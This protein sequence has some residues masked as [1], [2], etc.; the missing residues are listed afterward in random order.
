MIMLRSRRHSLLSTAHNKHHGVLRTQS[1]SS[2]DQQV[3]V[4]FWIQS[5][6]TFYYKQRIFLQNLSYHTILIALYLLSRCSGLLNVSGFYILVFPRIFNCPSVSITW[7]ASNSLHPIVQTLFFNG[8][9][10]FLDDCTFALRKSCQH[11][12]LLTGGGGT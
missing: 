11:G 10:Y 2:S 4:F 5:N 8:Y 3:L 6:I 12:I 7:N 1:W 9:S